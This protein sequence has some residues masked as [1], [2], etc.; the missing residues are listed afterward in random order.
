MSLSRPIPLPAAPLAV[1]ALLAVAIAA[2]WVPY[3]SQLSAASRHVHLHVATM[4]AWMWLLIAQ[5][6]LMRY[7]YREAHRRL[8]KLAYALMPLIVVSGLLLAHHRQSPPGQLDQPG[9]LP[10]LVLQFLSPMLMAGFFAMALANRRLPAVHARWM[11]ATT[12]LL[13]DPIVARI[14]IF[15]V[16]A[17]ADAGEWLGPSIAM[18]LTVWLIFVERHASG[19]RQVFPV[20]LGVLA[21]QQAL[22]Y[23]LGNSAIWRGFAR[24]FVELPLT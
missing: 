4:T 8:G 17:W 11:L 12:L 23:T 5:P 19:G 15:Y 18:A 16:P 10:L 3:F 9:M 14:L 13:I 7:G 2:F 20:V 1:A 24:W 21:I 6:L 22:Y